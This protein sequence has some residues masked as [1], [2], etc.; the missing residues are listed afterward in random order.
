[1][2][3]RTLKADE[4]TTYTVAITSKSNIAGGPGG[5][6]DISSNI[7]MNMNE[8]L[9]SVDPDG[10]KGKLDLDFTDI[11]VDIQSAAFP[12]APTMPTELKATAEMDDHNV[13][14]ETKI[15]GLDQMQ[16][17]TVGRLL[18]A[19]LR[20]VSFPDAG[21]KVGDTWDIPA[22]LAGLP[23][24]QAPKVTV[25][26]A[27]EQA[28]DGVDCW[29]VTTDQDVTINADLSS[30]FG[31]GGGTSIVAKG[32][33]HVMIDCFIEKTSGRMHK[34]HTVTSTNLSIDTPQ[35]ALTINGS[36]DQ[37]LSVKA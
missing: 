30:M 22:P 27:G 26:L 4:S 25:K 11:K 37:T 33:G 31:G 29:E 32:T 23:E 7:S 5:D 15:E 8:K 2:L 10:K 21:V 3:R 6:T 9:G 19:A 14:S 24:D 18:Q 28:Q 34:Q 17:L 1:V 12:N 13:I 16:Q 20:P 36:S 35:G